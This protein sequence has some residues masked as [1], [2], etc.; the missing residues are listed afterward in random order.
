M[1]STE[2]FQEGVCLPPTQVVRG[3]D[4][5]ED[6]W[7]IIESNVR[8]PRSAITIGDMKAQFAGD[9]VDPLWWTL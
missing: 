3:G 8:F 9:E 5:V 4:P 2:I 6:I 7:T 1:D